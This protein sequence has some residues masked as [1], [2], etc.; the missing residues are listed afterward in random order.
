MTWYQRKMD[1]R[2]FRR[3][4]GRDR[5]GRNRV[6][7][8]RKVFHKDGEIQEATVSQPTPPPQHMETPSFPSLLP[9]ETRTGRQEVC[10]EKEKEREKEEMRA[11]RARGVG[12]HGVDQMEMDRSS[13]GA[14][15]QFALS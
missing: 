11:E 1:T 12:S 5:C 3:G 10:L 14:P 4:A 9:L 13:R 2:C 6:D 8:F 7:H 15:Q